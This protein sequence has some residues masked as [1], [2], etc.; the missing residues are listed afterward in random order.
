MWHE[1]LDGT[2]T[3]TVEVALK[4]FHK[5]PINQEDDTEVH[6]VEVTRPTLA[7]LEE[8][9]IALLF[10]HSNVNVALSKMRMLGNMRQLPKDLIPTRLVQ[11]WLGEISVTETSA[12]H[13]Q[14][15][16][17][18]IVTALPLIDEV[19]RQTG[20]PFTLVV[21]GNHG[22]WRGHTHC[23]PCKNK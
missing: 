11:E 1:G 5:V 7:T 10:R 13:R 9:I 2:V 20:H 12:T 15:L 21:C 3:S 23:N 22:V 17:W 19:A 8:Q 6:H 4:T 18:A 14:C 16:M